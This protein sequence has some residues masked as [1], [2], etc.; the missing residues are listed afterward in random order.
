MKNEEKVMTLHPQ[1]KK[2]VNILKR[3]YDHIKEFILNTIED[4]VEISF[5]D[6]IDLAVDQLTN[7]FDGKVI[8]YIVTIKLDLEARQLIERIPKTSPQLLRLTNFKKVI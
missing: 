7:T 8:W 2:G 5:Q 6:L 1:G 3:R 4:S